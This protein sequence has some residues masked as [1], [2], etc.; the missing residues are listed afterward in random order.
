MNNLQGSYLLRQGLFTLSPLPFP[1][2]H[3]LPTDCAFIFLS[4]FPV[5]AALTIEIRRRSCQRRA[6]GV[7]PAPLGEIAA[8]PL[9]SPK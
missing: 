5:Y 6:S 8:R 2:P 9:E 7:I 3:L 4:V 1:T